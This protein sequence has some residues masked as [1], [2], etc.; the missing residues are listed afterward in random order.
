MFERKIFDYL[1]GDQCILEREP[2]E[3][4]ARDGQLMSYQHNGFFHAMD[5]FREYQFLNDL[6]KNGDAPWKVWQ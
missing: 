3:R 5:T 2:L 4:L 1:D 6:W